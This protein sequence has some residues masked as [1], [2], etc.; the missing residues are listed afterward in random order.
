MLIGYGGY[1]LTFAI[2]GSATGAAWTA[3]ASGIALTDFRT[4]SVQGIRWI[5]GTQNTSSYVEITVTIAS[6][7]DATAAQGV[8]GVANV[9]LPEGTKLVIGGVTQRLVSGARGERSAWVLPFATGNTL[10]IRIYNDVNGV[11]SIVASSEFSI[12]EIFVGRLM[13]LC[14]LMGTPTSD[15]T[16]PTAYQRTA[17]GQLYQLMRK[18]YGQVAA[19]L[20][21]FTTADVKGKSASSLV[22]GANPAGVID[23]QTLR[24]LL[25]TTNVCA[26]CDTETEGRG[27]GAS[28]VTTNGIRYNQTFMQTNWMIARPTNI[29]QFSQGRSPAWTWNPSFQESC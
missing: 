14:T 26:V 3:P 1:A 23:L 15:I 9:S 21:A 24:Y 7:L 4:G 25:S 13:D 8:V 10:V 22:S 2:G 17:G 5:S 12:G 28:D 19:T 27:E 6:P 20:G 16:D 11:A 18:P 29:G